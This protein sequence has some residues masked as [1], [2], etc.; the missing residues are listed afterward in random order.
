[1]SW[2]W[3]TVDGTCSLEISIREVE[4]KI[5][6][7]VTASGNEKIVSPFRELVGTNT[8]F[9]WTMFALHNYPG[10]LAG[11][12]RESPPVDSNHVTDNQ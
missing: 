5:S 1:M 8:R 6:R 11:F 10:A 7:R 9:I 3:N 2:E 4:F 12:Q